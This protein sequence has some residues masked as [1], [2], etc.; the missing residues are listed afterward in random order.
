MLKKQAVL[1][2][3]NK[4]D[5]V[6]E[7]SEGYILVANNDENRAKLNA[8][9]VSNEI[10]DK[11]GDKE[12][13]CILSLALSEG[14][15]NH[16]NAF[17]GGLVLE[18]EN[19][20]NERIFT[21]E[22]A[23]VFQAEVIECPDCAFKFGTIHEQSDTKGVYRCPNCDAANYEALYLQLQNDIKG[24]EEGVNLAIAITTDETVKAHLIQMLEGSK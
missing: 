24:I 5:V 20:A 4:L 11:Y 10:I 19:Q 8:V 15:A 17:K 18:T 16:Y 12:T 22:T 3:L 14:Y 1:D 21:K 6:E 9:G 23:N 13:F 2:V 7:G